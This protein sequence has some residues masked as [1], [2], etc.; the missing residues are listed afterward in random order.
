MKN[1]VITLIVIAIASSASA[2]ITD[3]DL[4]PAPFRGEDGTTLQ[5]WTFDTSENPAL[6][7]DGSINVNG[8][9]S[10]A[11]VGDFSTNTVWKDEDLGHQ[12]VWVVDQKDDSDMVIDVPNFINDNPVKDIWVQ[13]VYDSSDDMPPNV[14]VL[15]EGDDTAPDNLKQVDGI[16]VINLDSGYNIA[17]LHLEISPNPDYELL[18]IRPRFC[19][20]YIDEIIVETQCIPEPMTMALLALGGLMIR[21][22]R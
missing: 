14:Y 9:A 16:D 12:G 15:P 8:Q 10:V 13:L 2:M 21:K 5:A 11:L 4:N 1:T 22:R 17:T 19:Q 3:N 6:P 7:I 20:V 18:V